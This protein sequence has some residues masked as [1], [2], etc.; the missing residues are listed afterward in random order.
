[1]IFVESSIHV[2]SQVS[3]YKMRQAKQRIQSIKENPTNFLSR[4]NN[5]LA[6]FFNEK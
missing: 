3:I 6:N 2:I 4:Q 1:M 5:L